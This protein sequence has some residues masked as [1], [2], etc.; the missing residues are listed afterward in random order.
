MIVSR[1]NLEVVQVASRDPFDRDLNG[2]FF[3]PSG[4]T[5]AGTAR[6]FL[7][8]GPL[9]PGVVEKTREMWRVSTAGVNG[10]GEGGVGSGMTLEVAAVEQ[11]RRQV[12]RG[13]GV[14]VMT[15]VA[16]A[17]KVGLVAVG[18]GG[19]SA[20]AGGVRMAVESRPKGGVATYPDW[21]EVVRKA[22]NSSAS[23]NL[24]KRDGKVSGSLVAQS[25]R[26]V[27]NSK[28]LITLL[29]AVESAA[30]GSGVALFFEVGEQGILVRALNRVTAQHVVGVAAT[31]K[32][33]GKWLQKDGWEESVFADPT[34]VVKQVVTK[35]A[36][37]RR[38]LKKH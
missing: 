15:K 18:L 35:V 33:E 9:D 19:G 22:A 5:V 20:S 17:T 30:G 14:A 13:N 31:Y 24:A 25:G 29:K 34:P 28:D 10:G 27:V 2:V 26:A 1:A 23:G 7:A 8:V 37:V 36:P 21:R 6:S 12:P 38:L 16:D 3:E 4:A 11:V 32:A